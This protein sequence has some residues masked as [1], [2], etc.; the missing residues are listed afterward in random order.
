VNELP[1]QGESIE[2]TILSAFRQLEGKYRRVVFDSEEKFGGEV[3]SFDEIIDNSSLPTFIED[4]C[5]KGLGEKDLK[6][7]IDKEEQDDSNA[8]WENLFKL[9]T[10]ELL[11]DNNIDIS[12]ETKMEENINLEVNDKVEI[13][14]ELIITN[15][16]VIDNEE[17]FDYSVNNDLPL[18]LYISDTEAFIENSLIS[19]ER[20]KRMLKH[21]RMN[22][23]SIIFQSEKHSLDGDFTDL[24]KIIKINPATGL[25]G[26]RLTDQ[27]YIRVKGDFNEPEIGDDETYYFKGH[28]I[29]KMKMI[30]IN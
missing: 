11:L 27:N 25:V 15:D 10:D 9:E 17:T 13:D 26:A 29:R 24:G 16:Q 20:F 4:L 8:E 18:L 7:E 22:N 12:N 3:N 5:S 30:F 23:I 14:N 6:V 28:T 19:P 1:S 21:C 2:T